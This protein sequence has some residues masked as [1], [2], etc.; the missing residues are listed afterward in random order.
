MSYGWK[1]EKEKNKDNFEDNT[2]GK[3]RMRGQ[4]FNVRRK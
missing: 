2:R 4:R 3:K 1:T